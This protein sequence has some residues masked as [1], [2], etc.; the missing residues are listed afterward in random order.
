MAQGAATCATPR[1]ASPVC[2]SPN[3]QCTP[4]N[5]LSVTCV[6]QTYPRTYRDTYI[7]TL[8]QFI[9]WCKKALRNCSLLGWGGEEKD[10]WAQRRINYP[11]EQL[12]PTPACPALAPPHGPTPWPRPY[13]GMMAA[14]PPT[15]PTGPGLARPPS[16]HP[17]SYCA[18]SGTP[19]AW[20]QGRWHIP[21][22]QQNSHPSTCHHPCHPNATSFSKI[23]NCYGLKNAQQFI[24]VQRFILSP[25]DLSPS[26]KGNAEKQGSPRI[27]I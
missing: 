22:L 19:M 23:C 27:E 16:P 7:D 1:C 14:V 24:V 12:S 9:K 5:S 11:P 20:R 17:C 13:P 21:F 6:F 4:C 10:K 2:C 15:L 26:R 3:S 18:R 25:S 8:T